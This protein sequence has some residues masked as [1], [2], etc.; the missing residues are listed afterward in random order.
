MWEEKA[1]WASAARHALQFTGVPFMIAGWQI[2]DCA[3]G[4]PHKWR[5]REQ[6]VHTFS[7][8]NLCLR[9]VDHFCT[10]KSDVVHN[11]FKMSYQLKINE[12]KRLMSRI[13]LDLSSTLIS[14]QSANGTILLLLLKPWR[15]PAIWWP[16]MTPVV[17]ALETVCRAQEQ[18]TDS[19]TVAAAA[20]SGAYLL[21]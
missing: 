18:Q 21:Y 9:C 1:G 19:L 3:S 10:W 15:R 12:L 17:S 13:C 7:F 8:I 11:N 5:G 14:W 6:A 4:Q 20:V 16:L 2:R